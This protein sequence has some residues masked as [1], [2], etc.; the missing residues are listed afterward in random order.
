MFLPPTELA[1]P[2]D[3]IDSEKP[4]VRV[5]TDTIEGEPQVETDVQ[6]FEETM[7]DGT[8]VKR[9]VIKTRQKQTIVKRVVMEGPESDLPT[10]EEQAQMMLNTSGSFDPEYQVYTDR[11]QTEPVESTDVQEFEETLDDGTIVKKKVV[12]KTEQQLKTE[13]TLME[14]TDAVIGLADGHDEDMVQTEDQSYAYGAP[15]G[16]HPQAGIPLLTGKSKP[17]HLTACMHGELSY[18]FFHTCV[19][20]GIYCIYLCCLRCIFPICKVTDRNSLQQ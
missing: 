20:Y 6:E 4:S 3:S 17:L 7:P 19:S 13:R 10:T 18:S 16:R 15:P 2:T 14:G 1:S 8:V 11:M 12:T 5:Y 9:K